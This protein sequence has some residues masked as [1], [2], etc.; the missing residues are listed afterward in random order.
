MTRS[1]GASFF[2]NPTELPDPV[3]AADITRPSGINGGAGTAQSSGEY[4]PFEPIKDNVGFDLNEMFG[5]NI[6]EQL[7][8]MEKEVD[9]ATASAEAKSDNG[10]APDG[11]DEPFEFDS[12]DAEMFYEMWNNIRIGAH[13]YVYDWAIYRNPKKAREVLQE[14]SFKTNRTREE[15]DLMKVLWDYTGKHAI[16]RDEYIAAVPY[17][18]EHKDLCVR[19][20]A[21]MIK[22]IR[23]QGKSVPTWLIGAYIFAVPEVT[24]LTKLAALRAQVPEFKFD[25]SLLKK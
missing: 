16:L 18:P 23:L 24:M 13:D 21:Y 14:L 10:A 3:Q 11:G 7:G 5:P 1:K 15:E 25:M 12:M 6:E 2:G 19:Y 22:R 9:D 17:T 8:N 4:I 20:I